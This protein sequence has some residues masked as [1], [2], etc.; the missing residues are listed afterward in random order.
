MNENLADGRC[1]PW[2]HKWTKWDT[3]KSTVQQY[4]NGKFLGDSDALRQRRDCVKCGKRQ[5]KQVA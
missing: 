3:Y 4:S 5:D 2:S 1:W